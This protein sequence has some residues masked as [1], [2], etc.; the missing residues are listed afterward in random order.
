MVKL[1]SQ[2]GI[3]FIKSFEGFS[4][5][6]YKD[7]ANISTL[8]YGMTGDEIRGLKYVTEQQ[9]SNMLESLI[10]SK[11]ALPIKNNLNSRHVVLN[12]NQFDA[13]VSMAYNIGLGGLLGSTLYKNICNGI[14]DKTTITKNFTDWSKAG[15]KTVEGL[16]RRRTE[17]AQMFFKGGA[18]VADSKLLLLQK[19]CNRVGIRGADGKALVEDGLSGAN[20][21]AAKVKLIAYIASVTK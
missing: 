1:V 10:D 5:T 8:G 14:R 7:I 17:E 20:T 18:T 3:A 6:V 19:V 9:A 12:Q 16:L 11:Y 4:A 13:I 2:Q 15:S 21:T